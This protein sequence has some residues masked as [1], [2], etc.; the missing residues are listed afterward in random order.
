[1]DRDDASVPNGD[2]GG[3]AQ[4][5][6]FGDKAASGLCPRGGVTLYAVPSVMSGLESTR[7]GRVFIMTGLVDMDDES[8]SPSSEVSILRCLGFVSVF[9]SRKDDCRAVYLRI[10]RSHCFC[11]SACFSR[12]AAS[13][14]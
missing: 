13:I 11:S 2:P 7:C 12:L 6:D 14:A 4:P 9:I 1:M 8:C 3:C 5:P 10:S